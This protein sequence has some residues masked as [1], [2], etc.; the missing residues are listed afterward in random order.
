MIYNYLQDSFK[1]L[2]KLLHWAWSA[3]NG[4]VTEAKGHKG[5]NLSA[6]IM[7]LEKLQYIC[8][9]SLRLLKI[10]ICELFPPY[11]IFYI[12]FSVNIINY[13]YRG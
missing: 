7:D 9:A 10:Y 11:G 4:L 12:Q 13:T 5:H 2:L 8:T 1:A 6:T 3:F